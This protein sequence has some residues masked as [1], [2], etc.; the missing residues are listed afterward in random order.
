[1]YTRRSLALLAA[2]L[3]AAAGSAHAQSLIGRQAPDLEIEQ[4]TGRKEK[5]TLDRFKGRIVVLIFWRVNDAASLDAI[6]TLNNI[7]KNFSKGG[8][9]LIG[10][11]PDETQQVESVINGRG[12]TFRVAV[13][14]GAGALR[15]WQIGAYPSAYI[16]D[17]RGV[18]VWRG[19][20]ADELEDR[21]REQLRRTIGDAGAN[22]LES[23]LRRAQQFQDRKEYGRAYSITKEVVDITEEGDSV[24]DKARGQARK[25]EE[26]ADKWLDEA[27]ETEKKG[28]IDKACRIFA[29]VSVRF[30]GSD[31]AGKADTEIG[32]LRG[33]RDT[34]HPMRQ[35][36]DNARG[37]LRNDQAADA[38]AIKQY[39][40]ALE[41]YNEV[42]EKFPD[43]EAAKVAQK[44]I[45]RIA[46]DP[47]VLA[48]IK[49]IRAEDQAQRWL[50]L[51]DR[52]AAVEMYDL[53]R[54]YY[55][56]VIA[57]HPRSTAATKAK[58]RLKDLPT[59]T[60]PASQPTKRKASTSAGSSDGPS[61]PG[62]P[63]GGKPEKPEKPEKPAKPE[64]G[65]KTGG[66]P[67]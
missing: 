16:L 23:R 45:D 44:A 33:E 5:V 59:D 50:D 40:E 26:S 22:P 9:V 38:E 39:T 58:A 35:A 1:M 54:Q 28:E 66:G 17:T 55:E 62:K 47:A 19:H 6:P 46:G 2:L 27:R 65:G 60:Q 13:A 56:K 11:S 3:G 42:V 14:T 49:A 43:T 4:L 8:L 18:V 24:G 10:V 32:R 61:E 20:P 51:G 15:D 34:K 31:V 30:A 48:N 25:L 63:E 53:A 7:H 29:E 41:I 21:I 12:I 36:L 67:G 64:G 37:E 52:F 57:E